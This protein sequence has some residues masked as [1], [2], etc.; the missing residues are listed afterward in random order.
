MAPS[1]AM[2]DQTA[3]VGSALAQPTGRPDGSNRWYTTDH[4]GVCG[5][6]AEVS[7]PKWRFFREHRLVRD[8]GRDRFLAGRTG[9]P[10]YFFWRDGDRRI[11]RRLFPSEVTV[12]A[13]L[14]RASDGEDGCTKP[15]TGHA[16]V[17]SIGVAR[18]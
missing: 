10:R 17:A 14:L 1:V 5:L 7:E 13:N 18:S 15:E 11:E 9:V 4:L 16:F 2:P 12:L 3:S 8:L 6:F